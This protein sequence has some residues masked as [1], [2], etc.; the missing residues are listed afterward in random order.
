MYKL[1]WK[2]LVFHDNQIAPEPVIHLPIINV[3]TCVCLRDH[4]NRFG[5]SRE[6]EG[7][8]LACPDLTRREYNFAFYCF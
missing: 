3:G 8:L 5:S 6:T 1:R 7:T 4:S 2:E